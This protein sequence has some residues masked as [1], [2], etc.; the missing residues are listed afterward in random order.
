MKYTIDELM[1]LSDEELNALYNKL[2]KIN[3]IKYVLQDSVNSRKKLSLKKWDILEL[4]KISGVSTS[5]ILG[6][7]FIGKGLSNLKAESHK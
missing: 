3:H 1:K 2:N 7:Y 6:C 5:I 4:I